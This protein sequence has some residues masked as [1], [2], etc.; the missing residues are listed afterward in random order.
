MCC[1][2]G[3]SCPRAASGTYSAPA[4]PLPPLLHMNSG[5]FFVPDFNAYMLPAPLACHTHACPTYT[6][7]SH[8]HTHACCTHIHVCLQ[9]LMHG[10]LPPYLVQPVS[11]PTDVTDMWCPETHAYDSKCMKLSPPQPHSNPAR[12]CSAAAQRQQQQQQQR[13]EYVLGDPSGGA[14]QHGMQNQRNSVEY[15]AG[16]QHTPQPICMTHAQPH[17]C[18]RHTADVVICCTCCSLYTPGNSSAG[19]QQTAARLNTLGPMSLIRGH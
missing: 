9:F 4:L 7:M 18:C 10:H 14:H 17:I 3:V 6:C 19:S 12:H 1:R 8:V 16:R 2:L 5:C 15:A 13:T 11:C